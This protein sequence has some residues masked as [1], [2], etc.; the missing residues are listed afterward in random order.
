M[1]WFRTIIESLKKSPT[2]QELVD[3]LSALTYRDVLADLAIYG[4]AEE[5]A[6]RLQALRG[7]LGFSSL[8]AWMNVGGAIP[9]A[10]VLNS[11]RSFADHVIPRLT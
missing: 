8:S 5:V 7:T 9:H 4:A 11:M 3:R 10:R 1:L 2:R 6:E